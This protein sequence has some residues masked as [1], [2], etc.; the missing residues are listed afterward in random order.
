MI[1]WHN[2]IVL[3]YDLLSV[4]K[5]IVEVLEDLVR[6]KVLL[7]IIDNCLE[8]CG[9]T[10]SLELISKHREALKEHAECLLNTLCLVP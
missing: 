6:L 9:L 5:W 8:A 4:T 10:D 1:F 2:R 7:L 3:I